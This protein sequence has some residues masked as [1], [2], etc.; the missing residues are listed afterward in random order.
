MGIFAR[1]LHA[2]TWAKQSGRG[3]CR[4]VSPFIRD[5]PSIEGDILPLESKGTD[6]E[7]LDGD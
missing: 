1:R 7:V 6:S 5:F 2:T 3:L 4:V